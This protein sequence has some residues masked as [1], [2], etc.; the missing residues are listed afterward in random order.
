MRGVLP[1][2]PGKLVGREGWGQ[3]EG[4]EDGEDGEVLGKIFSCL[5]ILSVLSAFSVFFLLSSPD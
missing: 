4:G 1:N 2:E 5:S 3:V